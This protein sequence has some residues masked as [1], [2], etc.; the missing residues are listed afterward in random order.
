MANIR[1]VV[2]LWLQICCA[3]V[4]PA[5]LLAVEQLGPGT[6]IAF[7]GD[8]AKSKQVSGIARAGGDLLVIC[9]DEG[10]RFDVLKAD[11]ETDYRLL[12][13][14]PLADDHG[15]ELDLEGAAFDGESLYLV[16]SH[17]LAR[18]KLEPEDSY[19]K[20]RKRLKK[21]KEDDDDRTRDVLIR[22]SISD[23]GKLK[24]SKP[25]SLRKLL[26]KDPILKRFVDIPS[27]ENGIDIEGIAATEKHLYVGFRG[28]VLRGNYA[29]V[30]VLD[31]D[32]PD[33]Y[34]L[35][36]VKLG[37]RGIRDIAA[38]KDGFLLIAGPVGDGDS[39]FLLCYWNGKDCLEGTDGKGGKVKV[40]GRLPSKPGKPEGLAVI[41]ETDAQ[42]SLML[43]SDGVKDGGPTMLTID[44]SW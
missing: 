36:F 21:V 8:I 28:P 37:G 17:S 39:S 11:G 35:R 27:K 4:L 3:L 42:C 9:P 1:Y 26:E 7:H 14:I 16:G 12:N 40:L 23:D 43:V 25:V 22:A 2:P 33:D 6:K 10:V 20:N 34:E 18:T 31:F 5:Q 29:P 13:S 24:D 38:V 44:K 15:Q 32:A 19:K 41:K 30:M